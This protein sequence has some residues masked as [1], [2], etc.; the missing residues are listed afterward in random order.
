MAS[1]FSDP[2][3]HAPTV[4]SA[5]E[6]GD[7]VGSAGS[8]SALPAKL[9]PL[10]RQP[11]QRENSHQIVRRIESPT[12][13]Q[14]RSEP[15]REHVV[16]RLSVPQSAGEVIRL[17]PPPQALPL[18][19]RKITAPV[20]LAAV[21]E[22]LPAGARQRLRRP[23]L[24]WLAGSLLTPLLIAGAMFIKTGRETPLVSAEPPAPLNGKAADPSP[25]ALPA[26][27]DLNPAATPPDA[28]LRPRPSLVS[29]P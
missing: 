20:P 9:V 8:G 6:W 3:N 17:E 4:T 10:P 7:A 15:Q 18:T 16:T 24:R 21:P 5:D 13:N 14:P 27:G 28:P 23:R 2:N 12:F 29:K 1:V 25:G 26:A 19:A 11:R 22:P